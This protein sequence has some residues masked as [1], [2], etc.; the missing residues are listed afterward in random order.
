MHT[1]L[2][3]FQVHGS[4]EVQKSAQVRSGGRLACGRRR[5][6]TKQEGPWPRP[7]LAPLGVEVCQALPKA[8][9]HE[10]RDFQLLRVEAQ[11]SPALSEARADERFLLPGHLFQHA[12]KGIASH[13]LAYFVV[14]VWERRVGL[15]ELLPQQSSEVQGRHHAI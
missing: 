7:P 1:A 15:R 5:A 11:A 10:L 12:A 6:E 9:K 13:K 3:S 2:R 14:Q 4:E 8:R